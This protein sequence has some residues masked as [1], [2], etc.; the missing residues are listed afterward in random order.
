MNGTGNELLRRA[1]VR[2]CLAVIAAVLMLAM[3]TACGDEDGGGNGAGSDGDTDNWQVSEWENLPCPVDSVM[4][5]ESGEA[6]LAIT[7]QVDALDT[8]ELVGKSVDEASDLAEA[9]GC[10]LTV[11]VE[12]GEG[13]TQVGSP[14]ADS[15]QVEVTDD[16]VTTIFFVGEYPAREAY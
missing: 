6:V 14:E 11:I 15:I 13:T 3:V 16:K 4:E 7:A 9:H 12:D 1:W 8:A 2:V 10:K 5:D